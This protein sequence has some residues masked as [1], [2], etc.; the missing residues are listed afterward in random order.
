MTYI[1]YNPLVNG[2]HGY[3]G[4]KLI[5]HW[6]RE[7]Q[8]DERPIVKNVIKLR[9]REFFRG[10]TP[11]D[12][13]ILCGGDGTIHHLVNDLA[14]EV[15]A[16]P[17]YLW[18]YGT[19]NDFLRD[20]TDGDDEAGH[21]VL[22][23]EHIRRLPTTTYDGEVVRYLNGCSLGVDAV[24]CEMLDEQ[25]RLRKSRKLN[26]TWTAVKAFFTRYKPISGRV[27]VDGETIEYK[28]IWMAAS[29][30]GRYQGGGM[31]FAPEQDRNG[32]LLCSMVW[33]GTTALGTLARFP[34]VIPGR[35]VRY[36][37]ICDIRYGHEITVELDEPTTI[38]FDG[39]VVP[40]VSRYTAR[41]EAASS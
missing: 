14:G 39:E 11:A 10:L 17:V 25:R 35:H 34:S 2:G 22:L 23:N 18:R 40:G 16:V 20:V 6:L 3:R 36:K 31:R 15:P 21:M 19:G 7:E 41:K 12:R 5:R 4:V 8:P 38:Q 28:R 24:V 1:L 13:V 9:V 33:H 26:Y 27:T 29:M 37:D 32:D 30:H